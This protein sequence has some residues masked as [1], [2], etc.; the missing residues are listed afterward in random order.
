MEGKSYLEH[1]GPWI[2]Q[3][4]SASPAS[5]KTI[6]FVPYAAKDHQSY[7]RKAAMALEKWGIKIVCEDNAEARE[8]ALNKADGIIVGGGNTFRLLDKL[9]ANGMFSAIQNLVEKGMPYAGISAGAN[10]AGPTIKTT[11]DMP[12]V[13]PVSFNAMNFV[14][15]QINAHYVEGAFYYR[16][17]N[18]ELARYNGETRNHRIAEFHEENNLPVVGI[19]EGTAISIGDKSIKIHGGQ[20]V[21]L[22]AKGQDPIEISDGN[23]L[24]RQVICG[25]FQ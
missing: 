20:A 7:I 14:P 2:A 16:N 5:P 1:A 12:I 8:T 11:N 9:Q 24:G 22:F 23:E 10:I 13:E 4:F 18:G 25:K 21:R 17:A 19:R 6:F 15:F 3:H